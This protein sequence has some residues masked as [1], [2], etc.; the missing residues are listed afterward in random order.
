MVEECCLVSLKTYFLENN[1]CNEVIFEYEQTNDPRGLGAAEKNRFRRCVEVCLEIINNPPENLINMATEKLDKQINIFFDNIDPGTLF[2][3]SLESDKQ[4][5]LKLPH[6]GIIEVASQCLERF[7]M[8]AAQLETYQQS[9]LDGSRKAKLVNWWL[10]L[11]QV[12]T[13]DL[14]DSMGFHRNAV[15]EHYLDEPPA[16]MNLVKQNSDLVKNM[17]TDS[18]EIDQLIEK[19]KKVIYPKIDE[20]ISDSKAIISSIIK[21]DVENMNISEIKSLIEEKIELKQTKDEKT[22][23]WLNDT[24]ADVEY[25]NEMKS[26]EDPEYAKKNASL[27]IVPLSGLIVSRIARVANEHKTVLE[28]WNTSGKKK[29]KQ[30]LTQSEQLLKLLQVE[31]YT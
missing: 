8:A 26:L 23:D 16:D 24:I 2:A 27:H 25:L 21:Q 19:L 3:P 11:I 28:L 31:N 15:P 14:L 22:L 20:F 4:N 5:L 12:E 30:K 29:Q 10:Q 17:L 7:E 1:I 6:K 13:D 18:Y 9:V